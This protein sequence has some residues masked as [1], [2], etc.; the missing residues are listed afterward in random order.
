MS[1]MSAQVFK[2][3]YDFKESEGIPSETDSIR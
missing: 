2:N 3:Y 1:K